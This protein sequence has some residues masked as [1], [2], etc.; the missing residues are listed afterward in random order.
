MTMARLNTRAIAFHPSRSRSRRCDGSW[1]TAQKYGGLFARP[2]AR[3]SRIANS[4]AIAGCSRMRNDIGPPTRPPRSCQIRTRSSIGLHRSGRDLY[5]GLVTGSL[6][7]VHLGH[8][9]LEEVIEE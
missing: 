7:L 9:L 5:R 6:P 1:S 3:P 2:S 8:I 4:V